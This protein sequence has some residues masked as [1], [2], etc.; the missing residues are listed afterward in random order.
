LFSPRMGN[1]QQPLTNQKTQKHKNSLRSSFTRSSRISFDSAKIPYHGKGRSSE[2][3]FSSVHHPGQ[4]KII[5]EHGRQCRNGSN[6]G[7]YGGGRGIY[8]Y[9]SSGGCRKAHHVQIL[10]DL[11]HEYLLHGIPRSN[12]KAKEPEPTGCTQENPAQSSS[13]AKSDPVRVGG[14]NSEKRPLAKEHSP[15]SKAGRHRIFHLLKRIGLQL[16]KSSAFVLQ[17]FTILG[18]IP[19]SI[20]AFFLN[21]YR[22]FGTIAASII[23]YLTVFFLPTTIWQIFGTDIEWRDFIEKIGVRSKLQLGA[24]SVLITAFFQWISENQKSFF[25]EQVTGGAL[26]CI[27]ICTYVVGSRQEQ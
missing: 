19:L 8:C 7:G 4:S 15:Q 24:T 23:L 26:I 27:I 14:V 3:P 11:V 17:K 12:K 1:H 20:G 18:L 9:S 6:R 13:A 21:V 2:R 16:F 22:E 5:E 10:T 25:S